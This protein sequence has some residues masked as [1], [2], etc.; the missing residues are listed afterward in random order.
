MPTFALLSFPLGAM[1]RSFAFGDFMFNAAAAFFPFTVS[2]A[3][4]RGRN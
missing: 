3:A 2:S 4:K 1:D